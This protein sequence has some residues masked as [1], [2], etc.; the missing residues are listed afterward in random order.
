MGLPARHERYEHTLTLLTAHYD[1]L[2]MAGEGNR[3][4]T[5]AVFSLACMSPDVMGVGL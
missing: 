1:A 4:S 3:F 2:R 5:R